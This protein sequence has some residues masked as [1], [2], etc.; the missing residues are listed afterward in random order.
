M[1]LENLFKLSVVLN[2]VD[3]LTGPARGAGDSI[4]R[5]EQQMESLNQRSQ[6]WMTSGAGMMAAGA[7]IATAILLPTRATWETRRALGELSS[8]GVEN[9]KV[10]ETAAEEFSNQWSGTTKA[11]FVAAAYDIKGGIA[12]LMDEGVAEYTKL[13]AL[14]A[15]ATKA[16]TA[17]MTSLFATGYG[18]Y[19]DMYKNLSDIKFGEMFSGA[20]AT[21]INVF[22]SDGSQMAQALTTLGA[23][24]TSANRPLEEQIAVLGMLQATMPGG[25]A[26]TKYKAFVAAAAKAGKELGLSFVDS[27]NQLLGVT[28]IIERLRAKYGDTLDA[29]EKMEIA[30]AFGTEEAVAM[31]DLLYPKADQL[32]ES[33]K[34]VQD[35]MR[36]GIAEAQRMAQAMNQDPSARW[37]VTMQRLQ[38]LKETI[39]NELIPVI[40]PGVERLSNFI[41][42]LIDL[43]RANPEA[44]RQ[45]GILV[46]ILAG[47]VTGLG[48]VVTGMG[49]VTFAISKVIGFVKTMAMIINWS[50]D[51]FLTLRIASLYTMDAVK[52]GWASATKAAALAR[53]GMLRVS[54]A[55]YLM[56]QRMTLAAVNGA[57]YMA[58]SLAAMA[59][60]AAVTTVNALRALTIGIGQMAA[61]MIRAA[62]TALPGLIAATW[63]FTAALLANPITWIVLG[64]MALIG[65]IIL[66]WRNWDR[67]TAAFSAGWAWVQQAFQTAISFIMNIVNGLI[68]FFTQFGV[69]ILAVVAPFIG[70]PLLIIQNWG[71]IS[72]FFSNLWNGMIQSVQ[73]A[74]GWI[75]NFIRSKFE[76]FKNS[77][78][79]LLDAFTEGIKSAVMKPY[80]AAKE[81]LAKLRK[82]LPF[83]DAK[84]GPLSQLTRSGRAVPE[85]FAEGILQRK[86]LPKQA[87][88]AALAGIMLTV[89]VAG[90]SA[91]SVQPVNIPANILSHT[92][93]LTLPDAVGSATW[94]LS[95][96]AS[97]VSEPNG[98]AIAPPDPGD[99]RPPGV[100]M[101]E[102]ERVSLREVFRE[103]VTEREK[104]TIRESKRPI[105][106][107]V[108]YHGGNKQEYDRMLRDLQ[109]FLDSNE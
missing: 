37:E 28:E 2:M 57:R 58:T 35:G 21:A 88:A 75:G 1:G 27:Q 36:G 4:Q 65:V 3:R 55:A 98:V 54:T 82:L 84:E 69:Q 5:L 108:H 83:S 105:F 95:T 11:E 52:A 31:I 9:L 16:T 85:T 64:I 102:P 18:I 80:E 70:I 30:K 106:M 41:L 39:G 72:T 59:R 86:F 10:L 20:I 67:V 109:R 99:F 73:N 74:L 24:A 43:A 60:T 6:S 93:D 79:A 25:E 15:K 50:R 92:P 90:V 46:M 23:A 22:K 62:A 12:S 42:R 63:S 66:L 38:N 34:Q 47:L 77:G 53:T 107:E 48:F 87:M 14:T 13:A 97:V 17:E 19:K 91:A 7:G 26:G 61:Q 103:S 71:S 32:S 29:I 68:G 89:P 76:E 40:E 96:L 100:G 51:A 81:G 78:A 101:M 94:H 33:I 56:G 104:E 45:L 8:V 44:T 49:L